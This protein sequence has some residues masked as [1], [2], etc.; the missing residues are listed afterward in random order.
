MTDISETLA[1]A[2]LVYG[3]VPS[4]PDSGVLIAVRPAREWPND[5]PRVLAI[6]L[7]PVDPMEELPAIRRAAHGLLPKSMTPVPA[8]GEPAEPDWWEGQY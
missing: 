5:L 7:D 6:A 4:D 8:A 1:D 3:Y 2:D